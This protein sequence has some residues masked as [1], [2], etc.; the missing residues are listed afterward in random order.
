MRGQVADIGCGASLLHQAGN[1]QITGVDWSITGVEE[2]KKNVSRGTF[3]VADAKNTT[4]SSK[5]YDTVVMMGLLDYFDDWKPII[6]EAE[7]LK[8][9]GGHIFCTLLMGFQ[10][11]WWSTDLV[12]EKLGREPKSYQHITGNWVLIEV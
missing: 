7:R 11:H 4:L 8:K 3:I 2:A 5:T 10:G 9:D 6:D 12:K 1:Y